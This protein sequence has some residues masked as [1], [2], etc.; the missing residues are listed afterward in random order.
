MTIADLVLAIVVVIAG[1]AGFRTG[2]TKGLIFTSTASIGLVVGARIADQIHFN[3][4]AGRQ[5]VAA[6]VLVGCGAIG[7][8]GGQL[9]RAAPAPQAPQP[10]VPAIV[11]RRWQM[12]RRAALT[13]VVGA[14]GGFLIARATESDRTLTDSS[15]VTL[16]QTTAATTVPPT[17]VV[18]AT[19]PSTTA[20]SPSTVG[21]ATTVP[22]TTSSPAPTIAPLALRVTSPSDGT[23]VTS[24][25]VTLTGTAEPGAIV[26]VG[27]VAVT[28][29]A[30]TTWRLVVRVADGVN[31]IVVTDGRS[32]VTVTV[33]FNAPSTTTT[34]S[35]A[36]P[37]PPAP[38]TTTIPVD[39][40]PKP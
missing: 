18:H 7:L 1:I 38:T 29:A 16:P 17:T 3:N 5:A 25:R 6:V 35:T 20:V 26:K 8:A 11:R 12:V 13:L 10:Q 4:G 34:A 31:Q 39:T 30:D 9:L 37:P 21:T 27:T 2:A 14:A 24:S 32:S 28:A 36:P 22:A 23:K 19:F 15:V 33:V 40:E